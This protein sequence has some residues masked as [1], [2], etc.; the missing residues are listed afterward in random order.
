MNRFELYVIYSYQLQW[1]AMQL[2]NQSNIQTAHGQGL[3]DMLEALQLRKRSDYE[4]DVIIR[5]R[6]LAALDMYA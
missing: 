2:L 5:A 6:I 1:Q 4:T 3:D